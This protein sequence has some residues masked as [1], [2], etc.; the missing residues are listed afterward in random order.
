M[1]IHTL[2]R[3]ADET[4][5]PTL[6]R[7]DRDHAYKN[8]GP[9]KNGCGLTLPDGSMCMKAKTAPCHLGLPL[10]LNEALSAEIHLYRAMKEAWEKIIHEQLIASGLP[11]G[12]YST[13][14][15]KIDPKTEM[16]KF[17][18]MDRPVLIK[19]TRHKRSDDAIQA[20]TVEGVVCFP[21]RLMIGRDQGNFRWFLEKCVG[22]TMVNGGW[23][24]EDTIAPKRIY[25]FGGLDIIYRAN[26]AWSEMLLFCR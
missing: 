5:E 16:P 13:G 18:H 19:K 26:E 7:I 1:E 12:W 24:E 14:E 23:L 6:I 17:D 15:Q 8:R 2:D 22:D 25:E 9:R 21:N 3:Y 4:L 20:C 10:S 11:M